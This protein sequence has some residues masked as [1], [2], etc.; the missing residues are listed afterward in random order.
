MEVNCQRR[1]DESAARSLL[2]FGFSAKKPNEDERLVIVVQVLGVGKKWLL[3]ADA[4]RAN[5][6]ILAQGY[7]F[8]WTRLIFY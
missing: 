4:C 7:F 6:K 2:P 8:K 1:A 5:K 3:T